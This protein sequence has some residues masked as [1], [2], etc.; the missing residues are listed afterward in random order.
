MTI[1]W[2]DSVL[3]HSPGVDRNCSG[4]DFFFDKTMLQ[5]R[6]SMTSEINVWIFI[7]CPFV[8]AGISGPATCWSTAFRLFF[9]RNSA[10]SNAP[11]N[12]KSQGGRAANQWVLPHR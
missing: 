1:G 2:I 3:L 11:R 12:P 9:A 4:G 7:K 10:Y 8:R 5:Q 6:L